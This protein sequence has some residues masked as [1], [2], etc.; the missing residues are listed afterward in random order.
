LVADGSK[1]KVAAQIRSDSN[2]AIFSA[3]VFTAANFDYNQRYVIV[4]NYNGNG[5][6]SGFEITVNGVLQT[7][8]VIFNN[9][10]NRNTQ[11]SANFTIGKFTT[12][13]AFYLKGRLKQ[14]EILNRVATSGEIAAASAT[15]S[16][17]GAGIALADY[18]LSVDFDKTG[19]V[20]A[21]TR[22]GT[23]SYTITAIGG[24][25]YTQYL[26]V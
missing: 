17:Q 15:G 7:N 10:L 21:T 9:L 12:S 5:L 3:L 20:N 25:S 1:F 18:L 2:I 22:T 26:P 16:F 13:S 4:A 24:A 6:A 23:P 8:T 14:L 11:S 19:T